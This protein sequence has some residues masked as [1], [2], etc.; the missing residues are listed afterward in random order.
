MAIYNKFKF[1][2]V[3]NAH[4]S[5]VA[6]TTE[7]LKFKSLVLSEDTVQSNDI[8]RLTSISNPKQ[9]IT[10]SKVSKDDDRNN[11][12]TN[13]SSIILTTVVTNENLTTTYKVNTIGVTALDEQSGQ[14]VL[15][16]VITAKDPDTMPSVS[17][18]S[19]YSI[20]IRIR[21]LMSDNLTINESLDHNSMVLMSD[22]LDFKSMIVSDYVPKTQLATTSQTGLVRIHDFNKSSKDGNDIAKGIRSNKT[23]DTESEWLSILNNLNDDEVITAKSLANILSKILKPSS[24]TQHGLMTEGRVKEISPK[25]DL[26]PYVRYDYGFRVKGNNMGVNG[27]DY[28]I[29]ANSNEAWLPNIINFYRDASPG[30]EFYGSYHLNSHRAYYRV[31]NRNGNNWNEIVDNHDIVIRDNRLNSLDTEVKSAHQRVTDTWNKAHELFNNAG[32]DRW[33]QYIRELRLVGLIIAQIHRANDG[34]ER[35][36]YVA[37]GIQNWNGDEWVDRV[38][39]RALQILKNGNWYNIPFG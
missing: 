15:I 16:G 8:L 35:G 9:K 30:G 13:K 23:G 4:L 38:Y 25:P 37:T 36:G 12:P 18:A 14:E 6:S 1:T 5:R 31:P 10:I 27:Y 34:N 28:M 2:S 32:T 19:T 11:V 24:E 39:L 33:S 3:G 17:E 26:S 20:V 29:R 21:L 7:D 22:F